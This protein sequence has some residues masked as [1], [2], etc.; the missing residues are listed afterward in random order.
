MGKLND[1]GE[2]AKADA[3]V[4]DMLRS[5][6]EQSLKDKVVLDSLKTQI[7]KQVAEEERRKYEQQV[8]LVRLSMLEKERQYKAEIQAKEQLVALHQAKLDAV[9]TQLKRETDERLTILRKHAIADS[10]RDAASIKEQQAK[11]LEKKRID[12]LAAQTKEANKGINDINRDMDELRDSTMAYYKIRISTLA[13]SAHVNKVDSVRWM[14]KERDK[15]LRLLD[16]QENLLIEG[17][18]SARGSTGWLRVMGSDYDTRQFFDPFEA[19]KNKF[20][21]SNIL[22]LSTNTAKGSLYSELYHDY[23]GV[24]RVGVGGLL[25]NDDNS[26]DSLNLATD[27][28]MVDQ[29]LA[30]R[31][32]GG[33]GNVVVSFGLPL[34]GC[35]SRR[36]TLYFRGM[37]Q[38]KLAM[39]LQTA[40]KDR[41]KIP[42]Y[43]DVG[44]DAH[45][46]YSGT[47]GVLSGFLSTRPSVI[48]GNPILFDALGKENWKAIPMMQ[49]RLGI[50]VENVL[51]VSYLF[52]VGDPFVQ[53]TFTPQ[54]SI[55]VLTAGLANKN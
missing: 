45:L 36:G 47:E 43:A 15:A 40:E 9:S 24:V 20:L 28:S 54:I 31:I 6:V 55:Q 32:Q 14:T 22:S 50:G 2:A 4:I 1:E 3:V 13:K 30:Q 46:S 53:R 19:D 44:L 12:L 51:R 37:L 52:I 38:P 29:G 25:S 17:W 18:Y 7:E 23:F 35:S 41:T 39:D 49:V 8:N 21:Q 26:T 10:L 5:L 16:K 33:G 34:A 48:L 11:D 42:L 27:T